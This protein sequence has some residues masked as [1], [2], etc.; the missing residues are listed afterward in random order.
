MPHN[1]AYETYEGFVEFIGKQFEGK[2]PYETLGVPPHASEKDILKAYM[3]GR[4]KL[5]AQAGEE[6]E[7][8]LAQYDKAHEILTHS[9]LRAAVDYW[10]HSPAESQ[11][12]SAKLFT[13][14]VKAGVKAAADAVKKLEI[15][16]PVVA[17]GAAVLAATSAW[18]GVKA[19]KRISED[20]DEGKSA[21]PKDRAV[22]ALGFAGAASV[23]SAAALMWNA[24]KGAGRS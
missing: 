19:T 4:T 16:N 13:F 22:Q 14:P 24:S 2:T 23:V 11:A 5:A 20:K 18:A 9:D 6:A 10:M 21:S 3:I 1:P 12:E 17:I 15:T 8:R 7:K